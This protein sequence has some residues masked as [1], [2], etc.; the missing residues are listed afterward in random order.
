MHTIKNK[1]KRYSLTKNVL[2]LNPEFFNAVSFL[3]F[4][5]SM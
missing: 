4:F 3:T 2:R 5:L 1:I